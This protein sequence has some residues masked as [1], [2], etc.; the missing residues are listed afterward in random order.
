MRL[1]TNILMAALLF[2][3][4]YPLRYAYAALEPRVESAQSREIQ[5]LLIANDLAKIDQM[6]ESFEE[7]WHRTGNLIY[8]KKCCELLGEIE[9]YD[10]TRHSDLALKYG[11]VIV[12]AMLEEEPIAEVE[13]VPVHE[14]DYE[15]ECIQLLLAHL[16]DNDVVLNP[17][18]T[19]TRS[20]L[21]RLTAIFSVKIRRR[22]IVNFKPFETF[23][24]VSSPGVFSGQDPASVEDPKIR[25]AYRDAI[26]ENKEHSIINTQQFCLSRILENEFPRI[27]DAMVKAYSK[28]PLAYTELSEYLQLA[29]FSSHDRDQIIRKVEAATNTHAPLSLRPID[30]QGQKDRH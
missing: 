25:E 18:W 30:S 29:S 6:I 21:M 22:R 20:Q 15:S 11:I 7:D 3:L 12:A 24:N 5:A 9:I 19:A 23:M 26:R 14:F 27:E 2:M 10:H 13:W 28:D 8:F 1:G 16:T 17:S 4:C